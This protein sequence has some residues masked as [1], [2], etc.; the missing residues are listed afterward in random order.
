MMKF[1]DLIEQFVSA[2]A[3][4]V[5]MSV[6]LRAELDERIAQ[7]LDKK[8]AEMMGAAVDAKITAAISKLTSDLDH[9]LTTESL[10]DSKTRVAAALSDMLLEDSDNMAWINFEKRIADIAEK[11]CSARAERLVAERVNEFD[12]N[13]IVSDEVD[14]DDLARDAVNDL[15][16][17]DMAKEAIE[18]QME[19]IGC[20]AKTVIAEALRDAA[21]TIQRS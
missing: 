5:A 18:S 11:E 21:K 3:G 17:E 10:I 20:D 1:Q 6:R 8:V 19:D 7:A 16:L 12:F 9:R 13:D 15:N 4:E 14:F 2:L